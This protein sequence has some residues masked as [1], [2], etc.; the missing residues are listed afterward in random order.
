MEKKMVAVAS[1]P[2][3]QAVLNDG[4]GREGADWKRWCMEREDDLRIAIKALETIAVNA[5]SQLSA[6]KYFQNGYESDAWKCANW[7]KSV[8]TQA[9]NRVVKS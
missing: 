2:A 1:E 4:L 7:Y 6:L 8:A 5:E 3:Q 9:I